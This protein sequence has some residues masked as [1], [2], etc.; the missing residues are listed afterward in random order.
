M[1]SLNPIDPVETTGGSN[2]A[3]RSGK[4]PLIVGFVVLLVVAFGFIVVRGLGD[5]ALFFYNA[6]EAVEQREDLDGRRFRLQG[7]VVP[8]TVAETVADDGA[9]EVSFLVAH[10]DV[11]VSVRHRGDPPELF[12]DG[13]PVVLEGAWEEGGSDFSSNRMLVKHEEVYESDNPARVEDYQPQP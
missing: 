10:N 5:A 2:S 9:V 1:T 4:N 8:D 13:I 11:E 6:D 12:A 3:N 7:R